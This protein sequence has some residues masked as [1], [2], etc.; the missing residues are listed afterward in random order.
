M[1]TFNQCIKT[2]LPCPFLEPHHNPYNPYFNHFGDRTFL[3]K[4]GILPSPI[5][6]MGWS[7][8]YSVVLDLTSI[9]CWAPDWNC[10][11]IFTG[12]T[13]SQDRLL[14]NV[15]AVAWRPVAPPA[16]PIPNNAGFNVHDQFSENSQTHC[17]APPKMCVVK[18]CS[19]TVMI[20]NCEPWGDTRFPPKHRCA[21]LDIVTNRNWSHHP[22]CP[23]CI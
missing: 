14:A 13:I 22:T 16:F 6:T 10:S 11:H 7:F 9:T 20:H 17:K 8:P 23:L 3:K 5:W 1:N 12:R 15:H 2:R 19:L 21:K 18:I 4:A